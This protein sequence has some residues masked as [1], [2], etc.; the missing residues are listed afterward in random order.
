MAT[1][2]PNCLI[3]CS[4]AQQGVSAQSFIHSFTLTHSA[5]N[6]FIVT[7]EGKQIEF[8]K[9]DD[10]SRRWLNEFRAKPF[11]VP[12]KL[13]DVESIRYSALLIPSGLGCCYDLA[14]HKDLGKILTEFIEDKKP[15]CA[16]GHGTSGLFAATSNSGQ[17]WNFKDYSLTAPSLFEVCQLPE[18]AHLPVI[19]EDLIK[20]RGATYSSSQ[21]DCVHVVIDRHVIT[22]QNDNSTLS[23]VQN[24]ILLCNARYTILFALSTEITKNTIFE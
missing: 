17:Y 20:E 11:S 8:S 13:E 3:V 23:A 12:G 6:V 4:G 22:G 18:F 15:I 9:I 16:V 5:F 7:P 21:N 1:K 14:N 24:L 19:A 2:K 10:N